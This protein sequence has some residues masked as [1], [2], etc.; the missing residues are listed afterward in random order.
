MKQSE[1]VFGIHAVSSVLNN[2]AHVVRELWIDKSRL[3]KR[4]NLIVDLANANHIQ[5]HYVD[6]S[7]LDKLVTHAKH[8]SVV[9]SCMA[10]QWLKEADLKIRLDQ[11]EQQQSSATFLALD[12]IQD[13]HNLGACLRSADA[14]GVSGILIPKDRS[15]GLTSAVR[16]V[17]CGAI[18]TVQV[19]QLTNLVRSLRSMQAR[20]YWLYGL[21]ADAQQSLFEVKLANFNVLVLGTE[22][23]GLR[24]LTAQTCDQLLKIPMVGQVE[25]LNV[26]VAT[27]IC[28]FEA[29][30]QRMH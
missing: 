16:K 29:L 14:A 30:R 18:D 10:Q 6:K 28:V 27:G 19:F 5:V 4:I 11:I 8:Q 1:L 12:C 13:P 20:G 3:D 24:H 2:N 23:K 25:S 21:A 17:A 7:R 15:V 9:A 22:N 26:S